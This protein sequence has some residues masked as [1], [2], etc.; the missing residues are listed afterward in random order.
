MNT[1]L[2]PVTE[3]SSS[4]HLRPEPHSDAT[5]TNGFKSKQ[6]LNIK[7]QTYHF[8]VN[9]THLTPLVI[10]SVPVPSLETPFTITQVSPE[11]MSP[12]STS[13]NDTDH[14]KMV[15]KKKAR[16]QGR[17]QSQVG[18]PKYLANNAMFDSVRY[19]TEMCKNFMELGVCRFDQKC[20]YAHSA[21]ELNKATY[22]HEKY[23][24]QLCKPFHSE[25][26][27]DFGARC[28]FIHTKPDVDA[29]IAQLEAFLA[30]ALPMPHLDDD[31][32]DDHEVNGDDKGDRKRRLKVFKKLSE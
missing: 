1:M 3:T 32:G 5:N 30:S 4:G 31:T 8:N 23:K 9:I 7:V 28:A 21:Q 10:H 24:T 6:S 20:F 27:C 22:K 12:T 15:S 18:V 29:I 26:F 11:Q 25:G 2:L 13:S 16:G 17:G 14:K 19:K